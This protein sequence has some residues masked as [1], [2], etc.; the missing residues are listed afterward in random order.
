MKVKVKVGFLVMLSVVYFSCTPTVEGERKQ[1]KRNLKKIKIN[2][3]R[4][5]GIK[6]YLKD[7]HNISIKE[8]KSISQIQNEEE[9]AKEMDKV[10]D[11]ILS[12]PLM[13][14]I[15]RFDSKNREARNII[16]NIF[17]F[18]T[19]N[20]PSKIKIMIRK[21]RRSCNKAGKII[22]RYRERLKKS[23]FNTKVNAVDAFSR[24]SSKIWDI[25]TDLK[26]M[27]SDINRQIDKYRKYKT[28]KRKQTD[29]Q[30][31]TNK[32]DV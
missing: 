32:H 31:Q 22:L 16:K 8:M 6:R 21:A 27:Y 9:K 5:P 11:A 20:Y 2:A 29:K 1:F 17:R 23:M 26:R 24:I 15:S 4:F 18:R 30:K 25:N 10:N 12:D 7:L 28:K 19:S 14:N 3:K 13:R